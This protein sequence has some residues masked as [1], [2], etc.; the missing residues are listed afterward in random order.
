MYADVIESGL[1]KGPLLET[2]RKFGSQEAEHVA[3]LTALVKQMGGTP[4][5]KARTSFPLRG[6]ISA[7]ELIAEVEDLSGAAYL[8]QIV[9]VKNSAVLESMLAI[10]AVEG[11]HM[12]TVDKLIGFGITPGA[13]GSPMEAGLVLRQ[14]ESYVVSGN[15]KTPRKAN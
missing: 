8:G 15:G 5:A 14:A 4:V 6:R 1:I 9:H 7:L 13:F 10:F 11:R 12:S 3:A 2:I